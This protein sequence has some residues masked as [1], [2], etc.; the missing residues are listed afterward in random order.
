[1]LAARVERRSD[2]SEPVWLRCRGPRYREAVG[3]Q[4]WHSL[5]T[6]FFFFK[7]RAGGANPPVCWVR[8]KK[9]HPEGWRCCMEVPA[10]FGRSLLLKTRPTKP[11]LL[12]LLLC[13]WLCITHL[14]T[15]AASKPLDNVV[16]LFLGFGGV[17]AE[18][19]TGHCWQ[20]FD[21]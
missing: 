7:Y 21:L 18:D 9:N 15:D 1:M 3:A 14:H 13:G 5:R 8:A 10:K 17:V 11:C 6:A 16:N 20:R 2:A 19:F 12:R 4:V